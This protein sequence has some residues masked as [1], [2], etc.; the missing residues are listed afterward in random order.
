MY[1]GGTDKRALHV[2]ID[3]VIAFSLESAFMHQCDVIQIRLQPD[4]S[5]IISDNDKI[6]PHILSEDDFDERRKTPQL[7]MVFR[8]VN[9]R[10]PLS[11]VHYRASGNLLGVSISAV[12]PVSD[13]LT[14][15]VKHHT[16]VWK[17][18]FRKGKPHGAYQKYQLDEPQ[19][20]GV[21][22]TFQPDFTIFE[23]QDFD[24]DW[25]AD[26]CREIALTQPHLTMTLI[27]ER[28][29]NVRQD[30]F[31]Y[32]DGIQTLVRDLNQDKTPFHDMLSIHHT[33]PLKIHNGHLDIHVQI[34]MQFT[35]SDDIELHGYVNTVYS[36][37]GGTHIEGFQHALMGYLNAGKDEPKDWED[38]ARGLTAVINV[39][40]PDYGLEY[41][42]MAVTRLITPE[43]FEAVA[44]ATYALL[45]QN[46]MR[47][48]FRQ[49]SYKKRSDA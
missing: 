19:A 26:R 24:Y 44:S 5:V 2:L 25:L 37:F 30:V 29:S 18:T 1:F 17:R 15:T 45:I 6:L 4:H 12:T 42:S 40:Y 27:D 3:E 33:I 11:L 20:P 14:V 41:E 9:W 8:E 36:A 35:E 47:D 16:S 38:V 21:T 23:K 7:D 32:P 34:T 22:I 31:H 10:K 28:T 46:D 13:F 39:L 48:I 49:H 43:A